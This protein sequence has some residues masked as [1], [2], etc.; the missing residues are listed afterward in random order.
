MTL[1][2][3]RRGD[4]AD[5]WEGTAQLRLA[6][7]QSPGAPAEA[8][9]TLRFETVDPTEEA[10]AGTGWLRGG[11]MGQ[12]LTARAP[13][14]LFADVTRERGLDPGRLHDNWA[15]GRLEPNPGGV[16]VCDFDR[17]GYL[18]VLVTDVNGCTLYRGRPA[19][20]FEDVT[21]AYGLP[22]P[23]TSLVSTAAAWVDLD[24]DGWDDLILAGRVYRNDHGTRFTDVTTQTD[25]RLPY[26]TIGIVPADYDRDGKLDLYVTR[27]A[28][29]RTGAW[30][31][32][33]SSDSEG[34]LLFRNLGNWKFQNVTRASGTR[35]GGRS[36][37]TAAWLDAN[38]DGWPDLYVGNEF[39]DGQLL[40]NNR[41]GTFTG[42]A[43][44][45]R[46]SD[47]GT[48]GLAVG[49]VNN[50]GNIDVY[51][52]NMY[53]KAGTRVIGNLKP[54]AYPPPLME[55]MRRFVA[56]S[57]LHLNRGALKFDQAGPQMQVAAVGWA[58]GP[59][60]ADLDS[61]G[62]LDIFATAGYISRDRSKP[63][64]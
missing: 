28:R 23:R 59:C 47:F 5:W 32:G 45:D 8:V 52:A 15:G 51:S 13:R 42:Q 14:Y 18:D 48:M 53:S 37:F 40:V 11:G 2:P 49:D 34:N 22:D 20:R 30:A 31:E 54:D 4:L 33:T 56:G 26:N 64:G 39:G 46:P 43:M 12:T 9:I 41:D 35:G 57:Q 60:L 24:G 63:D 21:T 1:S 44:A 62:F 50:D 3:R 36:T 25:L 29:P 16:Y 58:Y 7:E 17:D 27:A 10:L 6:G 55:K 61:D 38:N 19:G